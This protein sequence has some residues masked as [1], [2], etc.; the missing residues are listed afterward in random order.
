MRFTSLSLGAGPPSTALAI[1][2][3]DKLTR[4][5]RPGLT[6]DFG[7]LHVDLLQFADTGDELD[8]TYAHL[9]K[10]A[11]YLEPRGMKLEIVRAS[12]GKSLSQVW[13]ERMA[14]LRRSA[15][16]LP[17]Y[18]T[19]TPEGDGQGRQ[20]CT[21][22]FKSR[23]LDA[24]AKRRARA[25]GVRTGVC[26]LMGYIIEEWKRMRQPKLYDKWGWTRGYPLIDA[27]ANRGWSEEVCRAALGYVPVSSACDHCAHRP[28]VGPGSR[29]WI[30]A[31]E[32]HRWEKIKRLDA[33]L[34][35]PPGINA[36]AAFIAQ[37]R[38]PVEEALAS[39]SRQGELFIDGGGERDCAA[40][41]CVV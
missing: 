16:A 34:R 12:H 32:P 22:E 23:V 17:L 9:P 30:K 38:L 29:A 11:A 20:Q 41:G 35:H 7:T 8:A 6:F 21:S 19:G 26:V 13:F 36:T 1:A 24:N 5:V 10:L 25:V 31:N 37:E 18:L 27:G 2:I 40:D 3:A 14:G 33:A 4:E 28:S 39:A 15:P